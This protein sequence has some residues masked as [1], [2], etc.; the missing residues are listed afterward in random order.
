MRE[1]N[2]RLQRVW[3]GGSCYLLSELW[4]RTCRFSNDPY[5]SGDSH[6]CL[7][8]EFPSKRLVNDLSTLGITKCWP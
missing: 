4:L 5:F 2:T 3:N 7:S 8:L 6:Y 1:I